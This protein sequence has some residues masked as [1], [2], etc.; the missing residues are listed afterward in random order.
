MSKAIST[1][2]GGFKGAEEQD[3]VLHVR[4]VTIFT[5]NE[6]RRAVLTANLRHACP[7]PVSRSKQGQNHM[8]E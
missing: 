3:D 6:E 5:T 2:S 7:S 8:A 4:Q 1:G